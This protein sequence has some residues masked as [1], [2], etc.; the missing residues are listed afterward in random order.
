LDHVTDCSGAYIQVHELPNPVI[1]VSDTV[2]AGSLISARAWGAE[3]YVW[4][5]NDSTVASGP[6]ASFNAPSSGGPYTVTCAGTNGPACTVNVSQQVVV[7]PPPQVAWHVDPISCT[8]D[9]GSIALQLPGSSTTDS[10][11]L[12]IAWQPATLSGPVLTGLS[13]GWYVA[14]VT[15]TVQGCSRT[16]SLVVLE[17]PTLN[18]A[19]Q[20]TDINCNGDPGSIQLV[21]ANSSISDSAYTIQWA[22][23][24]F[25]G[26]D[27]GPL[28]AGTYVVSVADTMGCSRTDTI[29]IL[30]PLS[31]LA[32]WQ[33]TDPTCATSADGAINLISPVG[34]DTALLTVI[35]ADTALA[36]WHPSGLSPGS[37]AV[38]VTDTMGCS[39]ND[40]IVINAPT[41]LMDSVITTPAYCNKAEGT[42]QVV[43]GSSAAGLTFDLG[44][45]P[46]TTTLFEHLLAG[47]YTVT[48]HDSAGCEQAIT[49]T[50]VPA[51]LISVQIG[52]DT[53]WAENGVATLTCTIVPQDSAS[54]IHWSPQTGLG[55]PNATTT[56]CQVTDTTT[57][58]VLAVSLDDCVATDT[59]VVV[60][61]Y[62]AQPTPTA[63]CGEFFLPD[64]FSPNGDGLNDDLCPM[65]GCIVALQWDIYDRW[66]AQV[67]SGHTPEACWGGTLNG[68]SLPPGSYAY[69]MHVERS[70]GEQLDRTRT[71]T[72]LR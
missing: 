63:P 28:P 18:I 16:D 42:A 58:V 8:N 49:F 56:S 54:I 12:T 19:W 60:P 21:L 46:G 9:P 24:G 53:V 68:A 50:I 70:N 62:T 38:T 47:T 71:I 36:G 66:G 7:L 20:H 30:L 5:V 11:A 22:Q 40:L 41:P 1:S 55:S 10:S 39:N 57:Y 31:A 14:T 6:H 61:H 25:S 45:G 2:C 27:P 33:G 13:A 44:E 48:A 67:Y 72:L 23:A 35:W 37:Y 26:P 15:D 52:V 34:T 17:P 69:T 3:T 65:G 4:S 32:Q 59:V 51:G 29:T 64:H 43:A